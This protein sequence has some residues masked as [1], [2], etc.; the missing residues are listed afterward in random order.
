MIRK[1]ASTAVS[2]VIL[3][4]GSFGFKSD[5]KPLDVRHSVVSI[6]EIRLSAPVAPKRVFIESLKR[7][8]NKEKLRS[9]G[10]RRLQSVS[11][12]EKLVRDTRWLAQHGG[13]TGICSGC[14]TVRMKQLVR[15]L[16][17]ARFVPVG[18]SATQ[19]VLCLAEN[20]SGFNPGAISDTNDWGAGQINRPSHESDHPSWWRP[21][22]GFKHAVLDPAYNVGI[23]F[24]M[25]KRGTSWTPWTGTYGRGMCH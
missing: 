11:L 21:H 20:E 6:S 2:V 5:H 22:A 3:G 13:V 9:L 12:P 23:M 19:T 4:V 24:A 18:A 17:V 14:A 25:S 16:I 1:I 7:K 15:A 8:L 10:V